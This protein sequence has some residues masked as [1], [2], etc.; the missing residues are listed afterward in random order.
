MKNKSALFRK[1]RGF[2]GVEATL[3]LV[4][5]GI[6]ATLLITTAMQQQKALNALKARRDA[7]RRADHAILTLRN[8]GEIHDSAVKIRRLS[9]EVHTPGHAWVEVTATV[10]GHSES[11]IG[12]IPTGKEA[13]DAAP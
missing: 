4:I 3:A 8:S 10:S 2:F 7:A 11:L 5:M 13:A 6:L 9:T 1:P 12:M